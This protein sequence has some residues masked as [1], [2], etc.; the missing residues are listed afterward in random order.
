MD[1]ATKSTLGK[2]EFLRL[3][4]TQMRYQ[5]P[6]NPMNSTD[7]TAQLAQFASLEQMTNVNSKLDDLLKNQNSLQNTLTTDLIGRKVKF[8]GTDGTSATGTVTGIT[9]ENDITYLIINGETKIQLSD[10]KEIA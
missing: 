6:L 1:I 8:E 2:D 9:F 7:F 3:F 10:I 4:V 5:D